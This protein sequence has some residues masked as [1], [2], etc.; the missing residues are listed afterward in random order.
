[1]DQNNPNSGYGGLTTLHIYTMGS[2]GQAIFI[3]VKNVATEI[4]VGATI[5]GAVC[6]LY[7]SGMST[8]GVIDAYSVFKPWVEYS[9]TA[10]N[11]VGNTKGVTYD[12]WN[13]TA[14][15]WTTAGCACEGDDGSDNDT[16]GGVCGTGTRDRKSTA[17]SSTEVTGTGW[18]SWSVTAAL[19][20]AWYDGTKNEE[21]IFLMNESGDN[22]N[23]D[24]TST[25]GASNQPYWLFT[26]TTEAPAAG[27][28]IMIQ[29]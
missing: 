12:D 7:C 14:E 9:L 21:G 28:I 19:A 20:Q 24:Y 16:D 22:N 8:A 13:C 26:Y 3:R 25:E 10:Q 6:S 4:G 27:Q 15:E 5:T 2:F 11:C 18:W 17:E 29:Q 1:M 23:T